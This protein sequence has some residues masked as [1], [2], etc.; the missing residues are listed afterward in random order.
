MIYLDKEAV[1]GF[2]RKIALQYGQAHVLVA[3]ANLEH[4]L[5][6]AKHY[7]E[8]IE[9]DKERLIK[10]AAYLL[11]HL[12]YDAHVFSDGNKRTALLAT[13]TF[14]E[15]NSYEMHED[16]E[17][18]VARMREIAEGKMSLSAICRW[19]SKKVKKQQAYG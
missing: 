2:N 10:K 18:L 14:L 3:E 4:F 19:L 12:A 7:G 1:V 15:L 11:Y 17:K 13:Q 6:Q 8:K 9:D 5:G 16:Q